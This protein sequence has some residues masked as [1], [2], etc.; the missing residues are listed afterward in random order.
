MNVYDP[1][2]MWCVVTVWVVDCFVG[3]TSPKLIGLCTTDDVVV[4]V[5]QVR[6]GLVGCGQKRLYS[7]TGAGGLATVGEGLD[8]GDLAAGV[9]C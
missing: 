5:S 2:V 9:A 7:D 8:S 1:G 6:K 3:S 4:K